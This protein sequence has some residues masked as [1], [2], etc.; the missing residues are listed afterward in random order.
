MVIL[1]DSI[2]EGYGV[3]KE[4]AY[5]SLLE[6]KIKAKTV[7]AQWTV[8]NASISGS[9]TAS[10][11]SRFKW[12]LRQKPELVVVALG[13]ND[14]LRGLSV[15]VTETNLVKVLELARDQKIQVVLCG[16]RMPPN[17]GKTYTEDFRSLFPKLAQK[18][19]LTFIPFLLDQVAGR[20]ELNLADG[21]HPNEKGHEIVAEN[22]YQAIKGL[23]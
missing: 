15:S 13:A 16:M 6:K 18:F 2:S 14:G 5:P 8:I 11:L 1:G 10:A 23:L 20:P 3:A 19:K 17:Y 9:T 22:V 21:I 4:S 7:G 12:Q